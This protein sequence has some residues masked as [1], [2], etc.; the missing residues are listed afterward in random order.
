[1]AHLPLCKAGEIVVARLAFEAITVPVT[2]SIATVIPASPAKLRD[3]SWGARVR[4]SAPAV[5]STVQVTTKA[6]KSW[7]ARITKVVAQFDDAALV[8]V[9]S[10]TPS[11]PARPV[12]PSYATARRVG[13]GC[14]Y[15]G[16]TGRNFC[17]ECSD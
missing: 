16:C 10:D 1:M 2:S 7:S 3:G 13:R 14:G 11:Q 17:D 12:R 6:G 8:A 15:P 9:E 4:G 5:G